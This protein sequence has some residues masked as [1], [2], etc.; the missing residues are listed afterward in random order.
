MILVIWLS[1]VGGQKKPAV[2]APKAKGQAQD[3][4]TVASPKAKGQAQDIST[5]A[6][7]KAEGQA[8]D[9]S[10]VASPK[11]QEQPQNQSRVGVSKAKTE[12]PNS[13]KPH[14]HVLQCYVCNYTDRFWCVDGDY[15]KPQHHKQ[16]CSTFDSYCSKIVWSR[17]ILFYCG[18]SNSYL[19]IP[20]FS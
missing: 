7:P 6:S 9:M 20:Y 1:M 17:E 4:S 8:Q 5:V 19:S 16:N 2:A 15:E 10:T 11:A 18:F 3:I 14:L 13:E 12:K